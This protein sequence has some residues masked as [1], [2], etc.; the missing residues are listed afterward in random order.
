[1]IK[2]IRIATFCLILCVP[3]AAS[4]DIWGA[5]LDLWPLPSGASSRV[6]NV[7]TNNIDT[8]FIH[9]TYQLPVG[10]AQDDPL[11]YDTQLQGIALAQVRSTMS[12]VLGWNFRTL[13]TFGHYKTP[14]FS[15]W[16]DLSNG[17]FHV[18]LHMIANP[19]N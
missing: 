15:A 17:K 6:I 18:T 4:A 7:D 8:T 1:M 2:L 11:L 9:I 3:T 13:L 5:P 10:L 12:D 14:Y 16:Y 19:P